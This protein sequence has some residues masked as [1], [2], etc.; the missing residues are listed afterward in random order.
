MT[1]LKIKWNKKI[2]HSSYTKIIEWVVISLTLS[3]D[4]SELITKR[5][6]DYNPANK[7]NDPQSIIPKNFL[8][9][10]QNVL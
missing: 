3:Q 6:E 7:L 2:K 10:P 8:E 4:L 5:K 9:N 1:L